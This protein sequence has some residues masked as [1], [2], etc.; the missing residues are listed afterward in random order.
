MWGL[1]ARASVVAVELLP[2]RGVGRLHHALDAARSLQRCLD[3]VP[4]PGGLR[5]RR[6]I[7]AVGLRRARRTGEQ[8]DQQD[9]KAGAHGG[10]AERR[11]LYPTS[12]HALEHDMDSNRW[13]LDGQLALVTGGSAG[14]GRAIASELLGFGARVLIAARD[15]DAL[16]AARE[17]LLELHPG[18]DLRALIADVSD[19]EQRREL[20]DWV[21]DQGE[22]LHILV[23]N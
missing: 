10:L 8:R 14:I 9:G 4:Q 2:P 6:R 13:R 19:D 18:G 23:N 1:P 5:F 21:E 12:V 22:G 11:P 7:V 15:G 20:L 3:R 17:E 16:E